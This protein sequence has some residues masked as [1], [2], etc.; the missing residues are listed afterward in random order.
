L[1]ELRKLKIS[2]REAVNAILRESDYRGCEYSFANN[3]AW[4]RKAHSRVCFYGG[5]YICAATEPEI[6]YVFPAGKPKTTDGYKTVI[7]EMRRYSEHHNQTLKIS[8][9]TAEQLTVFE[10]LFPGA[11]NI[12]VFTGD[13]DY[14]YKTEDFV[15]LPGKRYHGKRNH[16][17]QFERAYNWEFSLI[18]END[19]DDCIEFAAVSYNDSGDY[20]DEGKIFEQYAINCFFTHFNSLELAGGILRIDGKIAAFSI[21]EPLCSDTFDVHIE[22]ADTEYKGSYTAIANKFAG[23]AAANFKYINREEDLGIAGL[24][25]SKQSYLPCFQLEKHTIV[26]K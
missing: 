14:I 26:F 25:K 19:F 1:L 20:L 24:R 11:Y 16:I 2:D 4:R 6:S 7:E 8:G 22:K 5:F 9:V 10:E 21:G 15:G 3:L 17:A 18:T 13:F 12:E 23:A